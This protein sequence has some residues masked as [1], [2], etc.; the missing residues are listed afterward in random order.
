[1][2]YRGTAPV[3]KT[4]TS[5][6]VCLSLPEAAEQ[7]SISVTRFRDACY[8]HAA[9]EHQVI[10][11]VGTTNAHWGSMWDSVPRPKAG[12][13]RNPKGLANIRARC[14]GAM[15]QDSKKAGPWG[16]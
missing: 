10:L 14:A 6:R 16:L 3:A 5:I 12:R 4:Y 1:M 13:A 2:P 9:A 11:P 8:V 7:R 15:T